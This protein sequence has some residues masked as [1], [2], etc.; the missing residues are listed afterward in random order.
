MSVMRAWENDPQPTVVMLY[1]LDGIHPN[2]GHQ[3]RFFQ[4]INF[5]YIPR[6]MRRQFAKDWI[7][8]FNRKNGNIRLTWEVIKVKYPYLQHAVRRYFFKPNYYISDLKEVPFED[9]E[10]MIVSTWSKDFSRKIRTSLL[11]KFRN[12]MRRMRGRVD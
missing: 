4:A 2:T 5:T 8:E 6:A 7:R 1:A 10:K 11:S 12:V 9:M 3:W